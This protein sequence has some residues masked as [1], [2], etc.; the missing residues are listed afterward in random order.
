MGGQFSFRRAET[1]DL[2]EVARLKRAMFEEASRAHLLAADAEDL[3]RAH[4][5]SWYADG[6]AAH[7]LALAD[8]QIAALAGA[9]VKSDLPYCFF[10]RPSYGFIG[11][12]YT[13]P[14]WRRRGLARRLSLQA[15]AWLR[16]GGAGE[17]RLLASEHG[18][19]LYES[20]GFAP[21]DE[22][23]LQVRP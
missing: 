20:L 16:E 3:V 2:A 18:R 23:S 21:T 17:V 8:G 9:F 19:G 6:L 15:L 1:A 11:D 7:F 22:M 4:Y 13:L 14:A 5:Q 12:V 10:A